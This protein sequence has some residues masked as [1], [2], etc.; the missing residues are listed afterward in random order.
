MTEQDPIFKPEHTPMK[1]WYR[2]Q[3]LLFI[4]GSITIALLLVAVSMALYASSGAALLDLSR[5]GYKSIQNEVNQSD[6]FESY[7]ATGPVDKKTLE[8]FQKLYQRQTKPVLGDAYDPAAL[9]ASTLGI[10]APA[11]GE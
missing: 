4:G 6:S 1:P 3:L 5:P 7:P 11:A 10:D 8:D 2:H 9:D